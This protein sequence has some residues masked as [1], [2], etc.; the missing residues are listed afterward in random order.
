MCVGNYSVLVLVRSVV[1]KYL[2][3]LQVDLLHIAMVPMS[4]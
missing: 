2:G 4:I 1:C 3:S